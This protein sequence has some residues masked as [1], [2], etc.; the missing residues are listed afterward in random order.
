MGKVER[1]LENVFVDDFND[2]SSG[3]PHPNHAFS[4]Y[5]YRKEGSVLTTR[6]RVT[7]QRGRASARTFQNFAALNGDEATGIKNGKRVYG[8]IITVRIVESDDAMAA[9]AK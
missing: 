6:S 9:K 2:H 3:S 8:N 5:L 7:V 1:Q 4:A